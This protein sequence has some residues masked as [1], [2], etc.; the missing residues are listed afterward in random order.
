[1]KPFSHHRRA[2]ARPAGSLPRRA[3]RKRTTSLRVG[4]VLGLIVVVGAL[5][6]LAP[7]ASADSLPDFSSPGEAWNVLPPGESG[8]LSPGP[9]SVDQIPLYDGLTPLFDQVTDADLPT[10]FKPSIFGLGSQ[11]PASVEQPPARPGLHI[12]RDSKGVAHVFG[13]TRGEVMYG[14]GWVTVEDRAPLMELLRGPGRLAA[15]DAPGIDPFQI[16]LSLRQFAPS[17]QTEAFLAQQISLLESQGPAGRQVV[18]DIDD[19]L[20]GINDARSLAGVPGPPWTRNDVVAV[21]ALI[22]ARFG[23]GGGDEARRAQFLSA[24]QQRLG[25]GAGRRVFNDLREQND[26]ESPVSVPGK[27]KLASD[28]GAGNAVIDAG[29]LGAAA[30]AAAAAAQSAQ[31]SASNALLLGEGLSQ[32]GHPLLVAGPQVGYLYPQALYEA[33]LHGGGIDARGATFPGSGPYVQLGRGQDFSWSATSSGTDIVDQYVETLCDGDTSYVFNG[34]CVAMTPFDAGTLGPGPGPPAGPVSFNQ[35]VH[36]PVSGYA[37]S[38]G[39][40]VAISN[41]RSTRGR[42]LMSALGFADLNSNAV[43]DPASFIAAM[44]RVELTFNWFYLDNHNIAMFSSGR[45]PVRADGVDLGLPTVGTG[46]AEWQG[47]VPT[48]K[49]PQA[50]NPSG[51]AIINWNNQ[52]AAGWTAADDEWAYGSVHRVELLQDAVARRGTHS[53]GS[54]VAA[55]NRAATQDIRNAQDLPAIEAVLQTGPAPSSREQQ[56]LALLEQWRAAGSSRLDRDLDGTIDAPGAAIMDAAWPRIADAVMGP[57]LGPQLADLSSLIARD[58]KANSQGSS[59]GSGWYGYVDKDL[60]RLVGQRVRGG[61]RTRFCG[62]G[63]LTACRSALWQALKEAGAAL[64]AAQG[65]SDPTQWRSAATAERI[66]F[67]PSFPITMRW[68]NRPTFQQAISYSGHR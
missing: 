64:A 24:L 19:Y 48:S 10:Y 11:T 1:M 17:A 49:H 16:A 12:D 63:E 34:E 29:S 68:T 58:N 42:E 31:R 47:F 45:V 15:V 61:F 26:P 8:S 5:G 65:T 51:S 30:A 22:G 54:L 57:V 3:A 40:R 52:P 66:S 14:A 33:D 60:R 44:S 18:Q 55:M 36:G 20:Q 2:P 43:H 32:N 7:V 23:K 59:Y 50:V 25:D 56:M 27:F 37:R 6:A 9:G 67:L 53:L 39:Q 62:A 4:V 35:T 41:K 28:E 46:T 38:N 21:G 13:T